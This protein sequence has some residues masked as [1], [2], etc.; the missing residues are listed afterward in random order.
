[1]GTYI[2]VSLYEKLKTFTP[3]REKALS[4]VDAFD[5]AD[6]CER[7]RKLLGAGAETMIAQEEKE[8][9]YDKEKHAARL[10]VILQNWDA[11]LQ[12]MAEE[13][14]TAAT[15]ENLLDRLEL[16]KKISDIG[17]EETLLPTIL[18]ATRDIRDKYV[19]SRLL[20]DLGI[21]P[22]EALYQ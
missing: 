7:L 11:I 18:G 20:W 14:P 9:K 16:P 12:I 21:S 19:L 13:L 17:T 15:L 4:Y 1:M 6:W 2:A 22:E 8:G 5:Y 10:E 3:D